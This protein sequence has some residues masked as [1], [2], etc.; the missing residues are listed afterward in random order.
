MK[1]LTSFPGGAGI[2]NRFGS[3]RNSARAGVHAAGTIEH[4]GAAAPPNLPGL[5]Y[6]VRDTGYETTGCGARGSRRRAAGLI[7]HGGALAPPN[8][9]GL[10]PRHGL[11]SNIRNPHNPVTQVNPKSSEAISG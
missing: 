3:G 1:T 11:V 8:L 10:G 5:G 9:P 2:G 6:G 7:R 4:G